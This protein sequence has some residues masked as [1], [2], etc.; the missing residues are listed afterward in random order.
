MLSIGIGP[1]LKRQNQAKT[2][3]MPTYKELAGVE[4]AHNMWDAGFQYIT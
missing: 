2:M 1:I 3:Y 4:A